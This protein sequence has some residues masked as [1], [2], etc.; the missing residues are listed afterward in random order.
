M[1][2]TLPLL[3]LPLLLAQLCLVR[4]SPAAPTLD[5]TEI[6]ARLIEIDPW[7]LGGATLAAHATLTDKRGAR[8][9]L[10]F[11]ARSRRY[12]PPFSKSVVRFTAPADLAGAGFLQIQNRTG[13]DD[14]YLFLPELKRARRIS[15]NLRGNSFMGTDFSF[16]DLD[17]RDLR[18]STSS[19]LADESIGPYACFRVNSTPTRADSPYSRVELWIRIDNS[20]PLRMNMYDKSNVLAK[21]FSAEEV[22]RVA[23]HWYITK[24][25]MVDHVHAHETELV[26]DT[27]T[28]S[29]D[30][31][32]DEFTV[33]NLEKL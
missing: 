17:R 2:K 6:I 12:D 22:R 23:G 15:G 25:H 32:E 13:D 33:R 24:S 19:R 16:A 11:N 4:P 14:R 30:V 18:E 26:I 29:N 28:P 3:L 1:K 27:I 9:E 31:A 10:S 5:V 21:T 7:G 8:R 20:L